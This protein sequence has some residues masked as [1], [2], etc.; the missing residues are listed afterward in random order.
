VVFLL[1]Y[2]RGMAGNHTVPDGNVNPA[3]MQSLENVLL[4]SLG[5]RSSSNLKR[6]NSFFYI[7]SSNSYTLGL[8][9]AKNAGDRCRFFIRHQY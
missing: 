4:V 9:Y 2:P 3:H 7:G 8:G 6:W 5:H 1:P